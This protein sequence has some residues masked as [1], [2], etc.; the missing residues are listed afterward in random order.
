MVSVAGCDRQSFGSSS[1][2]PAGCDGSR[3]GFGAR[4]CA[5]ADDSAADATMAVVEGVSYPISKVGDYIPG[6]RFRSGR[7]SRSSSSLHIPGE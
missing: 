6:R 2:E 7:Q 5:E 3:C 4:P 1:E